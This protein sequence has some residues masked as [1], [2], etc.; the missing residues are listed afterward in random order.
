MA[1]YIYSLNSLRMIYFQVIAQTERI[2]PNQRDL[3][4]LAGSLT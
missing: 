4:F 2:I 3:T 1:V